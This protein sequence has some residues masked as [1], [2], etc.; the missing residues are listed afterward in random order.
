MSKTSCALCDQ[1]AAW[2]SHSHQRYLCDDCDRDYGMSEPLW[3]SL[4]MPFPRRRAERWL[5]SMDEGSFTAR[6]L[7]LTVIEMVERGEDVVGYQISAHAYAAARRPDP[8]A[9]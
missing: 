5:R 7:V 3:Q 8:S 4:D 2:F 6:R 9:G 1:P